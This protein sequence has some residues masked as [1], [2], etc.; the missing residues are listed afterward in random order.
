MPTDSYNK[1][2]KKNKIC[3]NCD[4]IRI[5]LKDES[6]GRL[7]SSKIHTRFFITSS[8]ISL[9]LTLPIYTMYIK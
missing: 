5:C 4:H 1:G 6:R 7:S 8:T 3:T 9:I 2:G